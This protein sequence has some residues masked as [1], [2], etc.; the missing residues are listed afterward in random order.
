MSRYPIFNRERVHTRMQQILVGVICSIIII[1]VVIHFNARS[2]I[3]KEQI[4]KRIKEWASDNNI[5]IVLVDSCKARYNTGQCIVSTSV[6]KPV[7]I[8]KCNEKACYVYEEK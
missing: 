6:K 8:I 3:H 7:I 2:S 4:E 5:K 1:A